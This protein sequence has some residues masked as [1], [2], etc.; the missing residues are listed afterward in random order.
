MCCMVDPS[1]LPPYW[2]AAS[3]ARGNLLV[4]RQPVLQVSEGGSQV[5][6]APGAHHSLH[7]QDCLLCLLTSNTFQ[8]PILAALPC[9]APR[10]ASLDA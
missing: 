1:V 7:Q 10:F 9:L 6:V 3:M 5:G 2:V 8:K 4:E